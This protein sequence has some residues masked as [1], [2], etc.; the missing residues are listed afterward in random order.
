MAANGFISFR[1]TNLLNR[2]LGSP[3]GA[4]RRQQ[5]RQ[6]TIRPRLE[7]LEDRLVL[8]TA[9]LSGTGRFASNASSTAPSSPPSCF[10]A[11]R[12]V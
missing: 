5:L 12:T 10:G 4:Q 6:N 2:F 8:S 1:F 9:T 3:G 11:R 7:A